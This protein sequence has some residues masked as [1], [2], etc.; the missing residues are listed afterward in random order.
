MRR[1]PSRRPK[2]AKLDPRCSGQDVI[3]V[4]GGEGAGGRGPEKGGGS[5]R[6]PAD[7][8]EGGVPQEALFG[9]VHGALRERGQRYALVQPCVPPA[10]GLQP[11]PDLHTTLGSVAGELCSP[12]KIE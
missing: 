10:S 12:P 5:G 9:V 2:S 4:A 6:V 8:L 1:W 7:R 3:D 11:A